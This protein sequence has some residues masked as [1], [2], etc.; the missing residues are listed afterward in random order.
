M[1]LAQV[2]LML[3]VAMLKMLVHLS[4]F[5]LGYVADFSNTGARVVTLVEHTP[6]SPVQK[7]MQFGLYGQN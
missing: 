4:K 6:C 2:A 3:N 7:V 1:L 5:G